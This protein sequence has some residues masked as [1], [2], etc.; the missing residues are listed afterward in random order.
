MTSPFSSWQNLKSTPYQSITALFVVITTFFLVYVLTCFLY[1]GNVVLNYFETQPQVLVFFES[2]VSDAEAT[3]A[4]DLIAQ[5]DYVDS[6]TVVGKTDAFTNYQQQNADEPLLLSLLSPELFPASLSISAK[7]AADLDRI[8]EQVDKLDGVD[9]IDYR[10]DVVH[11]FLSWTQVIRWSNFAVCSFLAVQFFLVIM[12][13]TTMKIA[14][15]DG[16]DT[17][18]VFMNVDQD[19]PTGI[20]EE[21]REKVDPVNLWYLKL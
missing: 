19:V 18:L 8:R 7:S 14:K 13:I 17:A 15:K 1:I 3:A 16:V 2:K 6:V 4:G 10:Q 9:E 20:L 5:L 11:E 21:L 12:I